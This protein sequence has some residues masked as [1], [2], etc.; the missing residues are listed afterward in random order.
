MSGQMRC[1]ET[2][3]SGV[4]MDASRVFPAMRAELNLKCSPFN[5]QNALTES[6]SKRELSQAGSNFQLLPK[7]EVSKT[8][9]THGLIDP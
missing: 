6:E 9:L 3:A 5:V 4:R 8:G 7:K 2:F 1:Q